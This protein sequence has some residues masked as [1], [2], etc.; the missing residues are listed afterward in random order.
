[1]KFTRLFWFLLFVLAY[2]VYH[3]CTLDVTPTPWFDETLMISIVES[4]LATGNFDLTV[5]PYF[6]YSQNYYL[7][8][9]VYFWISAG[10]LKLWGYGIF[11]YRLLGLVAGL[12]LLRV[13]S[14]LCNRQTS[15]G[16]IVPLIILLDPVLQS[17]MHEGRMDTLA[18]LFIFSS[19]ICLLKFNTQFQSKWI[20]LSA[21]FTALALL[22]TPRVAF[23]LVLQPILIDNFRHKKLL[24][25][26][27]IVV[28]IYSSWVFFAFDS[29]VNW[30]NYY[31]AFNEVFES[32]RFGLDQ[33][34]FPYNYPLIGFVLLACLLSWRSLKE[35]ILK[36]RMVL[37]SI[38][39]ILIFHL[40]IKGGF[41]VIF[42]IPQYYY[43]LFKLLNNDTRFKKIALV[44][45]V[46]F[47]CA[48]ATIRIS[49]NI[50][51]LG[52]HDRIVEFTGKHI[53]PGSRV[54]GNSKFYYSAKL[55]GS[56]YQSSVFKWLTN[57]EERISYHKD[58]YDYEY[59]IK[60]NLVNCNFE[61]YQEQ[62]QLI[63]VAT[64]KSKPIAGLSKLLASAVGNLTTLNH[65]QYDC[66]IYKRVNN[67]RSCIHEGKT[68]KF[69]V[70]INVSNTEQLLAAIQKID[71]I[72]SDSINLN[73][74]IVMNSGKYYLKKPLVFNKNWNTNISLTIS[75]LAEATLS[76]CYQVST[77]GESG[78]MYHTINNF[79]ESDFKW[80]RSGIESGSWLPFPIIDGKKLELSKWP[81]EGMALITHISETDN[82]IT[83]FTDQDEP[84]FNGPNVFLHGFP[85]QDWWDVY[86]KV[87]E[88]NEE[89][90]II[91][92]NKFKYRIDQHIQLLNL[93]SS[94]KFQTAYVFDF[95][96]NQIEMTLPK[97]FNND[98]EIASLN[99]IVILDSVSG[100]SFEGVKFEG[101]RSDAI[102]MSNASDISFVGCEFTN[103]GGR[104]ILGQNIIRIDVI[105]NKFHDLGEGGI[106][107]HS[108]GRDSLMPSETRIHNNT[109]CKF[110][111]NVWCY[112]PAV[113]IVGVGI[114]VS[115]NKIYDGSHVG[116]RFIGNNHL[117][118]Q[119][120]IFEVCT[121]SSDVGVIYTWPKDPTQRGNIIIGNYL[122]DIPSGR[123]NG[124]MGVYLDGFASGNEV[125][126]NLFYR[127]DHAVLISSGSDNK[128][129]RNKFIDCI[130]V[131]EINGQGLDTSD[132]FYKQSKSSH[133]ENW[134]AVMEDHGDI[135]YEQYPDLAN[136]NLGVWGEPSNNIIEE[137]LFVTPAWRH[138]FDVLWNQ[139]REFDAFDVLIGDNITIQKIIPDGMIKFQNNNVISTSEVDGVVF[140]HLHTF[141]GQ[142]SAGLCLERK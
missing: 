114:E 28:A 32:F 111:D 70:V 87:D 118:K 104:A 17:N 61:S 36:D 109:F 21:I 69:Q 45:L 116:I 4:I 90:D 58:V 63:E 101:C 6:D 10:C 67:R 137:N 98:F 120:E 78:R 40:F 13:I 65:K 71:S 79:S 25:W 16:L 129:L 134:N 124:S 12:L 82:K 141:G 100:V 14:K 125:T 122:H 93:R 52:A 102:S 108:I 127:V 44:S 91:L 107:F 50:T 126:D 140:E 53:P 57:N 42:V 59:F 128:I 130:P 76:G 9:P 56:N 68:K 113:D 20:W 48:V 27:L 84:L 41:Y 131:L 99:N 123:R 105:S 135:F 92:K 83:L 38:A 39:S 23:L 132:R 15:L 33:L 103:I 64:Y 74:R 5:A 88:V 35:L 121:K 54:I 66:T 75:G 47:G 86:Q 73:V 22:T 1:M 30:L 26:P 80:K 94:L 85:N 60:D 142:K 62:D 138:I 55:N 2:C 3:L 136:Y 81:S 8:G 37:F 77:S 43:L 110:N 96:K 19:V 18:L 72:V 34:I 51:E 29:V 95:E 89:G 133:V 46:I 112:R 11:Q 24:L 97:H 106:Y 31:S 117:I 115:N 139:S 7:Y 49:V 119:N